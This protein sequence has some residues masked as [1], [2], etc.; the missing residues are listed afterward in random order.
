MTRRGY[1]H[2]HAIAGSG[3]RAASPG[4]S[5][6]RRRAARDPAHPAVPPAVAGA[7]RGLAR[8]LAGPAGHGDLRL[9]AGERWRREGPG[10]RLVSSRCACCPA[11]VLGPLAGVM[12][13]RWDRRYTMVVCD[14]L[15]FV[16]FA[17][18]P[19]VALFSSDA[20]ITVG[21]AA[22]ATFLIESD[23]ADLDP[24]QGRR[25]PEPDPAGPA[26]SRQP[27]H[28]D[29]DVRH[30]AGARRRGA[31]RAQP[32]LPVAGALRRDVA[33]WAAPSSLA[34]YFLAFSRLATALVVFFGIREISGHNGGGHSETACCASSST[35][36]A[37]SAGR[38]MVRGL[39]LGILGAF[40]AGGVVIGTGPVLRPVARRRRRD[41]RH[42]VRGDLHRSRAGHRPGPAPDRRAVPAA[43]VRPEHHAGRRLGRRCSRWRRTCRWRSSARCWSAPA[44]AWPSCPAPRCSAARSTTRCAAG[45]SRSCRPAPGW[46]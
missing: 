33:V 41:L 7:R 10:L 13:D 35:A 40:A 29:H 17:S 3:R 2:Q 21:W 26:G 6:R 27:A 1:G 20:A 11:L 25:G 16:L 9:G 15:R 42:P 39:V 46:C 34:L 30:H 19:T 24:G 22:I 37:S 32:A 31:G 43:L 8:R 4:G 23:H 38:R 45:S 44:R 5:Q 14:L 12:A 28:A 18:I 36:G